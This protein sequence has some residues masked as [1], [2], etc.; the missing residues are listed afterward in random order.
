VNGG[1]E[2]FG[3]LKAIEDAGGKFQFSESIT[4]NIRF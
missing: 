1:L 3:L 2:D 4:Y